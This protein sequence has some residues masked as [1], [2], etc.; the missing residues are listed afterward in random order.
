MTDL[1]FA[2]FLNQK[3]CEI[4]RVLLARY[5]PCGLNGSACKVGDPIPCCLGSTSFG[6]GDCPFLAPG[7]PCQFENA[8]CRLWLCRTAL[9]STDPKCVEALK[10]LEQVGYLFGL[11]RRPL[12][13]QPYT[14]ADRQPK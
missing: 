7:G 5:D 14:G 6:H 10:H 9:D 1:E 11:C 12:I 13:G 8:A 3:L 2:L 4:A